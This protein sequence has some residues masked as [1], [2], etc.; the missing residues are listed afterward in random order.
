MSPTRTCRGLGGL[1]NN[2]GA[3][4][5]VSVWSFRRCLFRDLGSKGVLS[6]SLSWGNVSVVQSESSL[7][8]SVSS[9]S[10]LVSSLESGF[11]CI[12]CES[13]MYWQVSS[14]ML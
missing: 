3:S 6:L 5:S 1:L 2:G 10:Q 7:V 12:G 14:N 11:V 13:G 4:V 9:P 8:L